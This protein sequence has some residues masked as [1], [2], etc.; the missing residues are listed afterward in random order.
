MV[1]SEILSGTIFNFNFKP[2]EDTQVELS[3]CGL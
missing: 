3:D 2:E 1:P